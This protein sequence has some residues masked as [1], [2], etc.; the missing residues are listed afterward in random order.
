MPLLEQTTN[1]IFLPWVTADIHLLREDMMHTLQKAGFQVLPS[2]PMPS[3]ENVFKQEVEE[4]LK[5]ASCSIH[6]LGRESGPILSSDPGISY[7]KFQFLK[8]KEKGLRQKQQFKIFVWQPKLATDKDLAS[9]QLAFMNELENNIEV[10]MTY[11]KAPSAIQ[12]A[13]DIRSL[14]RVEEKLIYELLNADIFFI[15]NLVD[16]GSATE[17]LDMLSDVVNVEKLSIRQD[18]DIDYAE[19]TLQQI[20]K[21]KMAVVYFKNSSDWAIPFAQQIWKNIGG[22]ASTAPI[23]VIGDEDPETNKSKKIAGPKL[24]SMVVMGVLIPLEI[25]FQFDKVL[26]AKGAN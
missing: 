22:A 1:V 10:E 7:A 15:N 13:D 23:L 26:E 24:I 12:L 21:S 16:E 11:S 4:A 17:V 14:M 25:K 3:N 20:K 19:L 5:V 18:S 8:S 9:D 6:I 2:G